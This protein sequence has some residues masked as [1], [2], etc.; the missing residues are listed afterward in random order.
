[1]TDKELVD[2]IKS[3]KEKGFHTLFELYSQ[4]VFNTI[5][6][7]IQNTEDAEELTQDTFV[8]LHQKIESFNHK[9]KLS[10]WIY[11]IAVNKT[12]DVIKS[13]KRKF[14]INEV[15]SLLFNTTI[16]IPDHS[17]PGAL[18]ENKE[19]SDHLYRALAKLPARQQAAYTL[20]KVE[21]R[22]NKEVSAI[23]ELSVSSVESLLIRAKANL[24][25]ELATYY[26]NN[27]E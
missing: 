13:N 19:L 27:F 21:G 10:T 25:K 26:K 16:D 22:G 9:S 20:G 4:R 6:N 24:K 8:T 15:K 2:F 5:V 12:L 23:L 1:M 3:D 18:V 11:R 14:R 7:L 17:H